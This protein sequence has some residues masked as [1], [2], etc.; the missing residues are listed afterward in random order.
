MTKTGLMVGSSYNESLLIGSTLKTVWNMTSPY[1][2]ITGNYLTSLLQSSSSSSSSSYESLAGSFYQ[3]QDLYFQ[4]S[5]MDREPGYVI[6]NGAPASDYMGSITVTFNQLAT[7]LSSTVSRT[8]GVTIGV[9]FGMV[10]ISLALTWVS[11]A[12]PLKSLTRIMER[13]TQFDFASVRNMKGKR[14]SPIS[15][16]KRHSSP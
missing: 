6:V 2:S 10:F 9:F 12:R 13:A 5:V 14:D 8:V 1:V 16:W 4:V 11:V 3:Y 15:E 7:T